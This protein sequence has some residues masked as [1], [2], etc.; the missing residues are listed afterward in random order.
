[1]E[2]ALE[3]SWVYGL[4]CIPHGMPMVWVLIQIHKALPVSNTISFSHFLMWIVYLIYKHSFLS[5]WFTEIITFFTLF[6]PFIQH[7]MQTVTSM[8][9]WDLPPSLSSAKAESHE[10]HLFLEK[11]F[12]SCISLFQENLVGPGLRGTELLNFAAVLIESRTD[13]K[14]WGSLS[15]I[16]TVELCLCSSQGLARSVTGHNWSLPWEADSSPFI[17]KALYLS[18]FPRHVEGS[19]FL[20]YGCREITRLG[21]SYL[22]AILRLCYQF[23]FLTSE[24]RPVSWNP[25]LHF[26]NVE[27]WRGRS[28]AGKKEEGGEVFLVSG[29]WEI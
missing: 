28:T 25:N 15:F 17:Y 10:K 21:K 24:S 29:H 14:L 12:Y 16:V 27:M 5:D 13:A 26:R 2:V 8:T 23:Y 20:S 1:M 11:A 9:K 22:W 3:V 6:T 18:V 4:N 7:Q 19:F